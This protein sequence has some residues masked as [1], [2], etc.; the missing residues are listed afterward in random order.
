MQTEVTKIATH[1]REGDA[2]HSRN[3]S[4][5]AALATEY[6]GS[7][8]SSEIQTG[9]R[10]KVSIHE[11]QTVVR[12]RSPTVTMQPSSRARSLTVPKPYGTVAEKDADHSGSHK[13]LIQKEQIASRSR[14]PEVTV[15]KL[16]AV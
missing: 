2:D 3:K 7:R 1:Y 6:T 4:T 11:D 13:V 8:G 16:R 15:P 10:S 14:P 9:A 12:S 5:L